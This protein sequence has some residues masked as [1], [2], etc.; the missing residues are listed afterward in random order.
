[1]N[2]RFETLDLEQHTYKV[3]ETKLP[4]DS[5]IKY[6]P[7]THAAFTPYIV[8]GDA[9]SAEHKQ[10]NWTNKILWNKLGTLTTKDKEILGQTVLT[11]KDKQQLSSEARKV[12]NEAFEDRVKYISQIDHTIDYKIWTVQQEQ[13]KQTRLLLEKLQ[14]LR[15][16]INKLQQKQKEAEIIT[17]IT[18]SSY[19]INMIRGKTI[20]SPDL[21]FDEISLF[22]PKLKSKEI[23]EQDAID[24][25][26]NN[27]F[28]LNENLELIYTNVRKGELPN[29][30]P[31]TLFD[32]PHLMDLLM[33]MKHELA[34][35]KE[36]VQEKEEKIQMIEKD[37][38]FLDPDNLSVE[39]QDL[40]I[41]TVQQDSLYCDEKI[42]SMT[43]SEEEVD[44]Q[45]N[46]KIEGQEY[47]YDSQFREY[48]PKKEYPTLIRGKRHQQAESS[49]RADYIN[50]RRTQFEPS[51]TP[52]MNTS[53]SV[54]GEI[55][56]L[57]CTT[58]EEAEERIQKWTQ[59]MSISIVKQ[60]LDTINT[61]KFIARTLLGNAKQWFENLSSSA[62]QKLKAS[63]SLNTLSNTYL[64]LR[65][66]FGKL[67]FESEVEKLQ[68]QKDVARSKI[69]QLQICDMKHENIK[70]YLC[71]FQD[72]Y[73]DAAYNEQESETILDMF[74]S[75][76]PDPWGQH[77]LLNYKE[78]IK[79]KTLL[80]SIGT[81]MTYLQNSINDQCN[82]NW[83][84]KSARK[85]QK[86]ARL[87][88]NYYGVGK[89]GCKA[90]TKPY[91]QRYKFKRRY[92]PIKRKYLNTYKKQRYFRPKQYF[93]KRKSKCKCYNCGQEG[94]ISTNCKNKKIKT[95]INNINCY[96][97]NT[98][99]E[100]L[101]FEIDDE[102][103]IYITD[104]EPEITLQDANYSDQEY[105]YS[106]ENN[107]V[108]MINQDNSNTDNVI[109]EYDKQD[110]DNHRPTKIIFNNQQFKQIM[111]KDLNLHKTQIFNNP[112]LKTYFGK[113]DV[114]YYV[115][116]DIEHPI[117]VKYVLNQK[118]I[119]NLPLYNQQIF[120]NEIQKI[121]EKDQNK[122]KNI[123]LSAVEIIIKAYFREGIDTPLEIMLCDDRITYPQ[124]G[125]IVDTLIGNL[126]Y[127]KVKFTK[128]INYSISTQD[129]N[130][131]KSLVMYWN[132]EGIEMIPN[133]KIFSV[134]LRN[135]YLLSDKHI[136]QNKKY[137]KHNIII[138]PIFQDV[139]QND[140]HK[141]LEFDKPESSFNKRQLKTY[142]KRFSN[143]NDND[144]SNTP[145]QSQGTNNN[146]INI[147]Q[148]KM[149]KNSKQFHIIGQVLDGSKQKTYPILIDTGAAQSYIS[150]KI[151]DI[152]HIPKQQLGSPVKS[153]NT[154][155]QT[156]EYTNQ[157][158]M[159]IGIYDVN[160]L[161]HKINF[162]GLIETLPLLEDG[163]D[164]I[165]IGIN[166]LEQFNPFI[167]TSNYLEL[168]IGM[169]AV[170]I[171]RIKEDI[172]Q[173]V[174]SL[175]QMN[176]IK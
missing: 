74:Y 72:Y 160:N 144:E 40:T 106:D 103:I 45:L 121:P 51:Y 86:S 113:R 84:T 34:S 15:I 173:I 114:K 36:K 16:E 157:A 39:I 122:I 28:L 132:L 138:E 8:A 164:Q 110:K 109:K 4:I 26:L 10:L 41:S 30:R 17:P 87:D 100:Q 48:K 78:L 162:I 119:V 115:V 145:S 3:N 2:N 126:I 111:E 139:I 83:L 70:G 153:K 96:E 75:K 108:N 140:K 6:P 79:G 60:N 94:H 133:S 44:N 61:E 174:E 53:I 102:D 120:E 1:M 21:T 116:T 81:R 32:T 149:L 112:I 124:D 22:R 123:H 93:N 135:L 46:V 13:Q 148:I 163:R 23:S 7:F 104:S 66:E 141:Y 127:Q 12:I 58:L 5:Y 165:L 37:E 92:I 168:N 50:Q 105:W 85:I 68:K 33:D 56:N 73:Y 24:K 150:S 147:P 57:D 143:S 155:N 129:K 18:P 90:I 38:E 125:S 62:K 55:L 130:L 151:I 169:K 117:D 97:F 175:S 99:N 29:R 128:I 42:E 172:Y 89:Y 49:R 159:L 154:D 88:C 63:S 101:E 107:Y 52:N 176:Q 64:A 59:S 171:P 43:S 65:A 11:E 35:L 136:V 156:H 14:E 9:G 77:I 71:E 152:E 91:K 98:M 76:L 27:T 54:A 137:Y 67:G 20:D 131:D 69:L 19:T 161:Q 118:R 95:K 166:V 170:T 25:I 167:I 158:H 31:E 134:R 142:S 47:A 80:D 82:K 146:I